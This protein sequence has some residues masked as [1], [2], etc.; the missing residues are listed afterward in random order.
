MKEG[1][2]GG[3]EGVGD[4]WKYLGAKLLEFANSV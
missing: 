2:P 1:S 3:G 4:L